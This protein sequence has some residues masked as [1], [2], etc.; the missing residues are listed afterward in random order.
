MAATT[1]SP[2]SNQGSVRIQGTCGAGAAWGYSQRT[3]DNGDR[4]KEEISACAN[5]ASGD[6]V[7]QT[8]LGQLR[9]VLKF[10]LMSFSVLS[11][12][13]PRSNSGWRHLKGFT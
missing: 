6:G 10:A 12:S 9:L 1:H 5:Q 7:W 11:R 8:H 4:G 2:L 13:D 3:R